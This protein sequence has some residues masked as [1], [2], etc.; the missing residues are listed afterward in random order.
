MRETRV[1]LA[2]GSPT[3][4]GNVFSYT[5]YGTV[6]FLPLWQATVCVDASPVSRL[7]WVRV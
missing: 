4:Q 7:V 3:L 5:T 6:N 1:L 2:R